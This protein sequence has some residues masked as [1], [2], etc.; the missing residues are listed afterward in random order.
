[1]THKPVMLYHVPKRTASRI[2]VPLLERLLSA[3]PNIR[4]VKYADSCYADVLSLRQRHGGFHLF[5]GDDASCFD[6]MQ[7]G[8]DGVISV[9]SHLVPRAMKQ[10]ADRP[11]PHLI[12]LLKK[13]AELCFIESSPAPLKHLLSCQG[14]CQ[15][16]LRLP[17]CPISAKSAAV[18]DAQFP[19]LYDSIRAWL[20]P[21]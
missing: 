15:E 5:S 16:M 18:L 8:M 20:M 11:E 10:A 2:S 6:A 7:E 19:A 21:Q 17:L 4:A 12:A 9:I 13:V 14:R 3:C 1:M